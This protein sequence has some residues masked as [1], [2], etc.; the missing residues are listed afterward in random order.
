MNKKYKLR[1][2][3]FM[4]V[5][6]AWAL[7]AVGVVAVSSSNNTL[8]SKQILGIVIGTIV[9]FFIAFVDYVKVI[10][11]NYVFYSITILMLAAVKI[12][13]RSSHGATRW[14]RIGGFMF[15]PSE[16]SKILLILFFSKLM[17]DN[18]KKAKTIKYVITCILYFVPPLLLVLVEPDLS[19][20]ILICLVFVALLYESGISSKLVTMTLLVAIPVLAV[21]FYLVIMPNSPIVKKYQ[22][23]RVL[24]WLHPED[25]ASTTAYQTMNSI[26]AIGSGQ[27][28]GK[29]YNTNEISSVLNGGFISE[30]DTDF[31]FTVIGEE[32]GFI[33]GIV[34]VSLILIISL[35]CL[36]IAGKAKDLSGRLIA[37]GVGA[38]IGFQGFMNIAVA[39]GAMP[40]TGLPLPLVSSGL[41]SIVSVYIG[42]G[43]V[44]NV[45]LQQTRRYS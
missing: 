30:S 35:R 45:G 21:G 36:M 31:I 6:M 33:G 24:A 23:E 38:W 18:R 34:V 26:M 8:T 17:F 28:E 15:Q 32:F 27:L 40:N 43:F 42:I 41:T 4:L 5:I 13:G 12:M 22:Q 19:T 37:T 20:S 29:G 11:Y 7:S 16:F 2:F 39:T 44:L 9:M 25:Y 3:D 14:L 1:N 10:K